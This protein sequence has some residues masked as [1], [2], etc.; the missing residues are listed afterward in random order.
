MSEQLHSGN[1]K[2]VEQIDT[3]AEYQKLKE[4]LQTEVE[5]AEN[6]PFKSHIESLSNTA[7]SEAISGKEFNVGD[8]VGE[9][10]R[11]S[12]GIPKKQKADTYNKTLRRVRSQLPA[13][14]RVFSRIVH[15]R[16]L[17][18]ISGGVGK[19]LAR[20]SALFGGGFGAL[21]GSAILLYAARY[22]G[23][24]YNYGF[25]LIT[26]MAGFA[27]GLLIEAVL[28]LAHRR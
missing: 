15:Q 21:L 22:Y 13:P 26:F 7:N 1:E 10:S 12:V 25:M 9:S 3:S 24:T 8:N 14:Q 2:F 11:Q 5:R 27:A 20:P 19:T 6:D 16:Q 17:D 4:Q 18:A 23:F 28:K